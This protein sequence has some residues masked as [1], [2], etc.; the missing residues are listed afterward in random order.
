MRTL[1]PWAGHVSLWRCRCPC[2]GLRCWGHPCDA[3]DTAPLN[4]QSW[5]NVT[6]IGLKR[7]WGYPKNKAPKIQ[8]KQ[9]ILKEFGGVSTFQA[10]PCGVSCKETLN[11]RRKSATKL[12]Q[13]RQWQ[14]SQQDGGVCGTFDALAF[15][16]GGVTGVWVCGDFLG[17]FY[18]KIKGKVKINPSDFT[19][20]THKGF[21]RHYGFV[22]YIRCIFGRLVLSREFRGGF[23]WIHLP[24]WWRIM[25]QA[26]IH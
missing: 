1:S 9:P 19:Q 2:R 3:P 22:M 21:I 26:Q 18:P 4:E 15:W 24:K 11:S 14:R 6:R 20:V 17:N 25:K 16:Y 5:N 13:G 23:A 8:V 12:W 10:H 7:M